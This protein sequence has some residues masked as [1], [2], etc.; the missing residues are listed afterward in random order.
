MSA[1]ELLALGTGSFLPTRQ[2][3]HSGHLLRWGSTGILFDPGEG[4]QR[5]MVFAGVPSK[6]VH[7]ICL[8]HL[9]GD[10]CLGL[11]GVL[12]RL[13]ADG[14]R[15]P[16][17]LLYPASGQEHVDRLRGAGIR[18]EEVD[19]RPVPIQAG[20]QPVEVLRLRGLVISAAA[21]D[22]RVDALGYRIQ[23]E[24]R[25]GLDGEELAR[26]GITG[27]L[28]GRLLRQGRVVVNGRVSLVEDVTVA[29][30][31][32]SF[33]FVQDTRPCEGALRLADGVDTLVMEATY[34]DDLAGKADE[35]GHSTALATARLAARAGAARLI[36]WQ[37]FARRLVNEQ[38]W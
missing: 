27:P 23:D 20:P 6:R 30:R 14:V 21:L 38:R 25:T 10:H 17:F 24:P 2:R 1:H 5:Q 16:V 36:H 31:C 4:T 22:H 15:R 32:A 13:S 33:A 3:N 34:L 37:R 11:P 19:L 7:V 9:H 8:T 26:R 35:Y 12:Q 28:V 18:H 29:R